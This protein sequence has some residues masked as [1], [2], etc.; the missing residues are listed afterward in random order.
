MESTIRDRSQDHRPKTLGELNLPRGT[1]QTSNYRIIATICCQAPVFNDGV[2]AQAY[3]L[4]SPFTFSYPSGIA[5]LE[6]YTQILPNA[7]SLTMA[8]AAP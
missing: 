3:G 5:A 7:L 4:S 8:G 1:L 2:H 6:P